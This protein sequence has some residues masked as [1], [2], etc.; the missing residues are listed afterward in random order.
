MPRFF[1]KKDVVIDEQSGLM[2]TKNA[3][4]LDFPLTWDEALA[5]AKEINRSGLYSYR[6]WKLPN[7][8]ELFS[9]M[10]HEMINPSLPQGHPFDNVFNGY[11]WTA[12]TCIRLPDQAWYVHLGGARVFKGMKHGSYMVWPVRTAENHDTGGFFQTGQKTCFD[13]GGRIMDCHGSGQDGEFQAGMPHQEPRFTPDGD[14]VHDNST[15]LTWM[16][17]A[18]I[19]QKPVDWKSASDLVSQMNMESRYG[20]NDWRIPGIIELESLTDL[21]HHTPALPAAHCFTDVQN[22]YWSAT[23]SMYDT[24]YAWVLYTVDGA[25]GV[26]YKPLPEFYLWPVR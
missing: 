2:W 17:N 8:R 7:R 15:G 19:S 13:G 1:E 14:C 6:D 9:L 16:K 25:V 3:N 11:Y 10:S 12:S 18:N 26:G 24:A 5:A 23:T 22:F 21:E 4:L 20:H